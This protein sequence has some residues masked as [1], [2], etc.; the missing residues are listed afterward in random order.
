MESSA[1]EKLWFKNE[2]EWADALTGKHRQFRPWNI[3]GH[4]LFPM[5]LFTTVFTLYLF[6]TVFTDDCEIGRAMCGP[7]GVIVCGFECE[8]TLALRFAFSW[9]L[10]AHGLMTAVYPLVLISLFVGASAKSRI[11]LWDQ[12]DESLGEVQRISMHA[13]L[14]LAGVAFL[15]IL[16]HIYPTYFNLGGN[17]QIFF[18]SIF[19][20]CLVAILFIPIVPAIIVLRD[21]KEKDLAEICAIEEHANKKFFDL[22]RDGTKRRLKPG[23]V[24]QAKTELAIIVQYRLQVQAANVVPSSLEV[25]KISLSSVLVGVMLPIFIARASVGGG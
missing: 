9:F 11:G 21:L 10:V 18:F 5:A 16:M 12:G 17:L 20:V 23:E 15:F 6:T 2:K 4:I 1:V 24:E 25:I 7:D 8:I 19:A 3:Q 22:L 14:Y 13:S